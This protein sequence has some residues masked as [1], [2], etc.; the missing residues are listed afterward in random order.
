M[1]GSAVN[2]IDFNIISFVW[3]IMIK[4]DLKIEWFMFWYIHIKIELNKKYL[5]SVWI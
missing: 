4:I 3:L 1:F 2:K 5:D